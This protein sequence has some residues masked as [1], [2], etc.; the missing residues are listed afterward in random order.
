MYFIL[1]WI[2]RTVKQVYKELFP[3]PFLIA[4][5]NRLDKAAKDSSSLHIVNMYVY[6]TKLICFCAAV[7]CYH[8]YFCFS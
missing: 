5:F 1:M 7:F 8:P 6:Q 2:Q 4:E 3:Y